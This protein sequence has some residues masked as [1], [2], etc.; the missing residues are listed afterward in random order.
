MEST[1]ADSFS[2]FRGPFPSRHL[3]AARDLQIRQQIR[4]HELEYVGYVISGSQRDIDHYEVSIGVTD[5]LQL[6][7]PSSLVFTADT[8]TSENPRIRWFVFHHKDYDDKAVEFFRWKLRGYGYTIEP[9]LGHV[10]LQAENPEQT[11]RI[12]CSRAYARSLCYKDYWPLY[13]RLVY[14]LYLTSEKINQGDAN[15]TSGE[16]GDEES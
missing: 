2:M 15:S 7:L 12:V 8:G 13:P 10:L 11:I 1:Q 9:D 5:F 4:Y 6:W 14:L 16:S 3:T